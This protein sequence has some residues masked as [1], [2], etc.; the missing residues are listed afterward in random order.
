VKRENE[1]SGFAQ[2][3]KLMKAL[4]NEEPWAGF[5]IGATEIEYHLVKNV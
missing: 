1:I 3:G 5:T 4:G 2:L